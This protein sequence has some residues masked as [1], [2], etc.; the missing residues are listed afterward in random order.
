MDAVY[1]WITVL[2][3]SCM[4]VCGWQAGKWGMKPG[5]VLGSIGVILAIGIVV[6]TWKLGVGNV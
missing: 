1:V 3:L 6:I 5:G 2:G 4:F